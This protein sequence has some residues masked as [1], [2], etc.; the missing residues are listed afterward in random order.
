MDSEVYFVNVYR[1]LDAQFDEVVRE[2]VARTFSS[3]V[4]KINQKVPIGIVLACGTE[5]THK[6]VIGDAVDQHTLQSSID[7]AVL[8]YE[9]VHKSDRPHLPH[10][11]RIEADLVDAIQNIARGARHLLAEQRIDM[12]GD[13]ISAV[14]VVD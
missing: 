11:R 10:Q 3:L 12:N 8:S 4:A 14:A 13:N 5:R 2:P 9:F 6:F 7:D 1:R